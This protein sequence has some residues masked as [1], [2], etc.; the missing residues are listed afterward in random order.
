MW[1]F[2]PL[3]NRTPCFLYMMCYALVKIFTIVAMRVSVNNRL[4]KPFNTMEEAMAYLLGDSVGLCQ[5]QLGIYLDIQ[6]YMQCMP[7]PTGAN[8]IHT[9]DA[10]YFACNTHNRW[11]NT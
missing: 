1:T 2:P 11:Y 8:I 3:R 10:G 9:F 5:C 7:N 4:R 6:D